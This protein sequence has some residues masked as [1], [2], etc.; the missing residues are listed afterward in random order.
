M[1]T[2][3]PFGT[4]TSAPDAPGGVLGEPMV[5]RA[6]AHVDVFAGR[7]SHR[8]PRW[9]RVVEAPLERRAAHFDPEFPRASPIGACEREPRYER[10]RGVRAANRVTEREGADVDAKAP[11]A[12]IDVRSGPLLRV[13]RKDG[14]GYSEASR[15]RQ[16]QTDACRRTPKRCAQKRRRRC[17][18]VATRSRR[19]ALHARSLRARTSA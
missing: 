14:T 6:V 4:Q 16:Q 7:A 19:K 2:T 17:I 15:H 11:S 13:L 9:R 3:T 18:F 8:R 1:P 10:K 12:L 5:M